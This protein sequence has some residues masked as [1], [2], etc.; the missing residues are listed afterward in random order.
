MLVG[1][2]STTPRGLGFL[3]GRWGTVDVSLGETEGV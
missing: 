1:A 2:R 3:L